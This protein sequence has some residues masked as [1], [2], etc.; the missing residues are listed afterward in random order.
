MSTRPPQ[1]WQYLLF[2]IFSLSG[3]SG[4]IYE[5][6][7]TNYLKFFLGHAAHAQT[8]VLA[9][10]MGGMAAG[11]WLAG[12]FIT[13]IKNPLLAYAIV[14]VI[15]GIFG[16]LFHRIFIASTGFMLDDVLP[17]LEAPMAAE[18]VR[19]GFAALLILPQTILLGATFP[20]ISVGILRS[21]P[22]TPGS[23]ISMLYFTNSIG[24]V[25]GVLTS[26]FYLIS[27]VGLPGAILAASLIN[28]TLAIL[29]Y[30]ICKQL[31]IQ[32]LPQESSQK[33][34]SP[35]LRPLL[36]VAM[37]TGL[38]S[39]IYEISW[40][41]MLTMVLGASTHAFELML[42]AFILGLALGGLWLH[43]RIDR[44]R[45]PLQSLGVIQLLMGVMAMMTVLLYSSSFSLMSELNQA[46]A[47]TDS[48]YTLFNLASHTIAAAMMLPTTVLAGMTLPLITFVLFRQ[49]GGES[50]IGKVYAFNTLGAIVGVGLASMLLLPIIGLKNAIIV[51]ACFDLVL[52][53]FLFRRAKST[54]KMKI[55]A[56]ILVLAVVSGTLLAPPFDPLLMSSGVFRHGMLRKP[57]AAESVFHRDGKT[58]TVDVN[59]TLPDR[60]LAIFTNGKPDANVAAPDKPAS[61]DESTMVMLGGLP[62]LAHPN[63][64][65]AAVIGMGAGMS[66]NVMLSSSK[67]QSLDV[68]EIEAAMVEGARLFGKSS[69]KVFT[70]PRSHIY[71][72]DAKSFFSVHK[73]RYDIIVSEPSDSWVSGV[74]SLFTDEFYT[75]IRKHLN[76]DGLMVQWLHMYETSPQ[77]VGSIFNA[78]GKNFADYRVYASNNG[79]IVI[80]AKAEG[81]VV[82][83]DAKTFNEPQLHAAFQHVGWHTFDD[84][85]LFEIGDR[86][87]LEP[88]FIASGAPINSDFFPYVDQNAVAA[89]FK[90]LDYTYFVNLRNAPVPMPGTAYEG[91]LQT[92]LD[93][94][95]PNFIRG[96]NAQSGRRVGLFFANSGKGLIPST[97]GMMNGVAATLMTK[98]SCN[99]PLSQINWAQNL[100][101]FAQASLPAMSNEEG[102]AAL[103]FLAG[104]VCDTDFLNLKLF[105]VMKAVAARDM[106]AIETA[107]YK[108]LGNGKIEANMV[109]SYAVHALL[110]SYYQQEKWEEVKKTLSRMEGMNSIFFDLVGAHAFLKSPS[111]Q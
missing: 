68:I 5:S 24:A 14:E 79:N 105:Q 42:S 23:S 17:G 60:S 37:I 59:R 107:S 51:G 109:K 92:S 53:L 86:Q 111:K 101:V 16:L 72:D 25:V 28:F 95:I 33:A 54:K 66:A 20:L 45:N 8:L 64:Q 100:I 84:V 75:R 36:M 67:L 2:F 44:F 73:K 77:L 87:L 98:P 9:L 69:E 10:F 88:L 18:L 3:F 55:S 57:G 29:V 50:A 108:I 110:L 63:A 7:W 15:I 31:N 43:K 4:L 35:L 65:S 97:V 61:G 1:H 99:D 46:L 85:Q 21:F 78:L 52:A 13:R 58:A 40:I 82:A 62:L 19:W 102:Q 48:G 12:R 93:M 80:L 39:F 71:I 103:A 89:R 11:A 6:V 70:D 104:Q 41:R 38:S 26:G 106:R 56:W 81:K 49:G 32:T 94:P 34:T 91:K 74:S 47:R 90:Q 96:T 22:N 83:L 27:A 76:H 30:G